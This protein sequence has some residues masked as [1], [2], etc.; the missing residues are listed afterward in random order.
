VGA[1]TPFDRL[2]DLAWRGFERGAEL[3]A[4]EEARAEWTGVG[5]R[6]GGRQFVTAMGEVT[7]I[8]SQPDLSRIPHTRPWV[9]G[10]ANVRGR[11]LPI[12]DLA[13]YLGKGQIAMTEESRVLVMEQGGVV[14]G[15]LVEE[16]LGMRR[17]YMEQWG[18]ASNEQ[19]ADI[20]PYVA[21]RFQRDADAWPVF[22]MDQLA[23]HPEFMK[24]AEQ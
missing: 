12:M 23:R 1:G 17:F 15:L 18:Q 2:Q 19:D 3:P 16:V 11:L 14:A 8:L 5:F 13:G 6:V 4:Q 7:E 20:A 22:S 24:V 10:I 21:G 9:R